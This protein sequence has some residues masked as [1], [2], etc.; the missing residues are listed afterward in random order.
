MKQAVI[1]GATGGIGHA[2]A[3]G[4]AAA[5]YFVI[6][7]DLPE[8]ADFTGENIVYLPM[9]LRQETDIKQ[10]FEHARQKYGVIDVLVN[11]GAI[12]HLQKSPWE[13]T[14]AEFD[15]VIHTNLRGTFLC[16]QNF[17]RANEG[18]DYGRII[19]IAS[20][21]WHQN[22]AGW[23]AYGAS[24]GGVVSLTNSLCVSLSDTAVTVN[25]ISP[26]WIETGD[27]DALTEADYKQH[28]SG[29]VGKPADILR[30]CLFLA[31]TE[32][33]FINGINLVV[34]GGMTKRM[35]YVE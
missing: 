9:D 21:R 7:T 10:F 2:L 17:L 3:E 22:E 33:D 12:S 24:K 31:A 28:P 13:L 16:C 8:T 11:C 32:S 20:T 35:I 26:G 23:E 19:N 34:D 1:T 5:G 4:F 15:N 27:Y 25:A 6:A 14:A 29:R 18:A 30:A